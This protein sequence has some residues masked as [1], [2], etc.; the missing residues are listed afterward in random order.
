PGK[1]LSHLHRFFA[2]GP[3]VR[4]GMK[5]KEENSA[6]GAPLRARR[7]AAA[8]SARGVGS[9]GT[10]GRAQEKTSTCAVGALLRTRCS[11]GRLMPG[12]GI[13]LQGG[14]ASTGQMFGSLRELHRFFKSVARSRTPQRFLR[15][16]PTSWRECTTARSEIQGFTRG[17]RRGIEA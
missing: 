3:S 14:L 7:R 11:L 2:V 13:P 1:V 12:F 5:K 16:L 17:R 10:V 9:G 6:Q 8:G 15:P 4:R